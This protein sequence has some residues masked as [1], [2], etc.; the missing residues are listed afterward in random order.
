MGASSQEFKPVQ[1]SSNIGHFSVNQLLDAAGKGNPYVAEEMKRRGLNPD[2]TPI[3]PEWESQLGQDGLLKDPYKIAADLSVDQRGLE[4]YRERALG[5]GDSAWAKL[6]KEQQ[7]LEEASLRDKLGQQAGSAQAQARSSLAMR[8]GLSGG[9]AE[10]IAKSGARDQMA[11]AQNLAAQGAMARGNIG[12]Q[13]EQMRTQMLG[14]LPGMELQAMQPQLQN[15]QIQQ[16]NIDKALG[17]NLQKRVF[18][19]NTYNQKMQQWAG[20][21][22]AQAIKDSD[23]GKK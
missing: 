23:S 5:T 3:R 4:K 11:G 20:G 2:G 12:L 6:A 16:W 9:A 7:G 21:Q 18:D 17:E 13:D 19:T 15:K 10:R 22:Q 14:N 1:H 8:G